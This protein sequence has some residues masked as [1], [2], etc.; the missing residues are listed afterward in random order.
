[1]FFTSGRF[2]KRIVL[3]DTTTHGGRVISASGE[4][5]YGPE[6]FA[7]S[8]DTV[9][10]PMCGGFRKIEPGPE[11]Q[12]GRLPYAVEGQRTSCG[13]E[14]VSRDNLGLVMREDGTIESF[15]SDFSIL[16]I[17]KKINR[18]KS[19]VTPHG[20]G[21]V[22]SYSG[23][24]SSPSKPQPKD[25][26]PTEQKQRHKT[27]TALYMDLK[28]EDNRFHEYLPFKL[29][30]Y[31]EIYQKTMSGRKGYVGQFEPGTYTVII[32]PTPPPG[33]TLGPVPYTDN[34]KF[35]H[36]VTLSGTDQYLSIT[37]TRKESIEHNIM[38]T[39]LVEDGTVTDP[40]K[41]LVELQAHADN[42]M[43]QSHIYR[44][45][46]EFGLDV[47]WVNAIC[48]METTHGWYDAIKPKPDSIQPMNI[49]IVYWKKLFAAKGLTRAE[50]Q[51]RN[52]NV[53]EGC[54]LLHRLF[55]RVEP[56][57]LLAVASLYNSHAA[58][59]LLEYGY[60]VKRIYDQKLWIAGGPELQ[61]DIPDE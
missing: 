8:G 5:S 4:P 14:L 16:D 47:N 20:S 35:R 60:H 17:C 13:A 57:T 6:R 56:K 59:Y 43:T 30:V 26:E 41:P 58:E 36:N 55:V 9:Y 15:S 50:L 1:M 23:G 18:Y 48:Y 52:I 46:T 44:Y 12:Y 49:N 61:V 53:R 24:A 25:Q 21:G 42:A 37:V 28:N 38:M 54:F 11:D 29:S 34:P 3:G 32:E 39:F 33:E 10:C 40:G 45:A 19:G 7:R 2:S 31:S 22:S 27:K 51:K